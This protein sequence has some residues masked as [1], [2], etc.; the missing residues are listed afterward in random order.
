MYVWIIHVHTYVHVCHCVHVKV[1]G[2]LTGSGFRRL[3]SPKVF[4]F[5]R[6]HL[7]T[8]IEPSGCFSTASCS[9]EEACICALK[10]MLYIF[11]K[12]CIMVL[13]LSELSSLYVALRSI[14]VHTCASGLFI[15]AVRWSICVYMCA[16]T[17]GGSW[18][19]QRKV[20][21]LAVSVCTASLHL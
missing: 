10:C 3:T 9:P 4:S 5:L 11:L 18:K 2:Q 20:G 1:R 15:T 14:H 12:A 8:N 13:Y 17:E 7:S 6:R 21:L 16:I 19:L